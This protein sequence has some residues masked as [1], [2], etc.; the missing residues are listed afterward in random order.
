MYI[1]IY[2]YIDIIQIGGGLISLIGAYDAYVYLYIH[3]H[4][5]MYTYIYASLI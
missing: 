4:I 3:V 5:C 1:Y 2:I